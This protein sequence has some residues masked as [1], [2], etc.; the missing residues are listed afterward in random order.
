LEH[1]RG[2]ETILLVEDEELLR[3]VVTEFLTHI[4]YH[5]L[6]ASN[7]RDA[8]SIARNHKGII[9]LLITDVIMPETSGPELARKLCAERPDL[10]VMYISGFDDGSLAPEGVLEPGT[11]LLTKPFSVRV[12]SAT[13]REVL[14]S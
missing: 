5:V 9:H 12:L 8:M 11:V 2:T 3:K 13:M 6:S 7:G 10:K 14:D 4:G 1:V